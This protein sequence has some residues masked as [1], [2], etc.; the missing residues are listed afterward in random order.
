MVF[1]TDLY[2]GVDKVGETSIKTKFFHN[3][4]VYS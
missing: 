3:N 1:G 2:G 4:G